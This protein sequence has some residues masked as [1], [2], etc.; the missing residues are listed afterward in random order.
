[1]QTE[2]KITKK[3]IKNATNEID[4]FNAGQAKQFV[5]CARSLSGRVCWN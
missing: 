3:Q 2:N 1:M 4:H 5:V